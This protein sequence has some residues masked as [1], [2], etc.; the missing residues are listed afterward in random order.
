M[1]QCTDR[2]GVG[3]AC[4]EATARGLA[5]PPARL[6]SPRDAPTAETAPIAA[7]AIEARK[8]T[9]SRAQAADAADHDKLAKP[10]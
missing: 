3:G 7:D 10:M 9:A 6:G 5:G 8:I 1:R 2:T 4:L